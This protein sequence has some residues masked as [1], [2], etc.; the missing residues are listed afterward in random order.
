MK[1]VM[2]WLILIN[3]LLSIIIAVIIIILTSKYYKIRYYPFVFL[4]C[5]VNPEPKNVFMICASVVRALTRQC[6]LIF[7]SVSCVT[8]WAVRANEVDVHSRYV[9][10][11]SISMYSTLPAGGTPAKRQDRLVPPAPPDLLLL[12][13][14]RQQFHERHSRELMKWSHQ[15]R[16]WSKRESQE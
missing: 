3:M 12:S 2:Y 6:G 5:G 14:G 9:F 10:R 8:S 11:L 13:W 4:I 7:W 15:F 1:F 16:S